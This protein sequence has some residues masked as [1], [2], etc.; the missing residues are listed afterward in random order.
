MAAIRET[1]EETGLLV[2]RVTPRVPRTRSNAWQAFL[3]HG[4]VPALDVLDFVA[5]AIT[6]PGNP[7]RFDARFFMADAS[8]IHGDAHDDLS[9]SGELLDVRWVSLEEA[10]NLDL[11]DITRMV[12]GQIPKR[13]ASRPDAPLPVP[14]VRYDR[15]VEYL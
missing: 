3:R 14:F 15:V 7:R 9:G 13:L 12:I 10:R 2:G 6:P 5:R 8:H 4:I 1:F 11:P